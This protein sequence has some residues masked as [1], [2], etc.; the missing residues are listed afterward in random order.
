MKP[1]APLPTSP[2]N[3]RARGRLNGKKPIHAA[4]S[5][6]APSLQPLSPANIASASATSAA[7]EPAIPLMPSMKFQMLIRLTIANQAST[8]PASRS[9]EHTSELQSL[10]RTSYAVF[11]LK[12]KNRN[13]YNIHREKKKKQ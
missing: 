1:I 9:E 4:A 7:C 12:K 13:N 5:S 3:T 8:E 6:S 11:C 2:R 10:M